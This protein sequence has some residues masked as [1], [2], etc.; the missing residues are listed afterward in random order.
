M[1]FRSNGPVTLSL[2][3]FRGVTRRIILTALIVYFGIGLLGI[4]LP[5]LALTLRDLAVLVPDLALRGELWMFLSY[6]FMGAGLLSV[7]FALLSIWFFGSTLEDERG[8]RWLMEYFLA[9][10]IGGGLLA[11]LL[12][13]ALGPGNRFI[14]YAATAGLWPFVLATLI[15]FAYFHPD[16]ELRFNFILTLKAKY[17]A[18]IYVLGYLALSLS[19]AERFGTVVV[20]LSA[21]CG[22][23]FL[24]FAPRKGVRGGVSERWYG[25][26][27]AYY[28]AKRKRSAKKFVVYM[29]KQGKEVSLDE[30]GRYVDPNVTAR[31]LKDRKWMN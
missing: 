30:D 19:E 24:R 7:G 23:V 20:L 12:A 25:L 22:F 9:T 8:G 13:V 11:S 18:A 5:K 6:P 1:A 2:P 4:V 3:P 31:D 21:L 15:A 10:T 29:K 26:R 14:P 17:L 28:R 27:N 16:Q